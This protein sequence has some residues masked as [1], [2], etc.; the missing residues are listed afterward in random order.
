[1][2]AGIPMDD[3]NQKSPPG[4]LDSHHGEPDSDFMTSHDPTQPGLPLELKELPRARKD[5]VSHLEER[6]DNLTAELEAREKELVDAK[7]RALR[8]MA[9][10]DNYR[11]RLERERDERM[12]RDEADLVASFLPVLDSLDKA[13]ESASG[14]WPGSAGF[15]EGIEH[16]KWQFRDILGKKGLERIDTAGKPFDP[17]TS[18]VLMVEDTSGHEDGVVIREFSPGYMI[19]GKVL[20]PARVVVAGNQSDKEKT[21]A[22][23]HS[24]G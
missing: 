9:E 13:L 17:V 2:T 16:T 20:R 1:M 6:I 7:D 14:D 8:A 24:S 23:E 21:S 12:K 18:Q 10:A 15:R 3:K 11:K 22:D 5:N 4:F 19:R